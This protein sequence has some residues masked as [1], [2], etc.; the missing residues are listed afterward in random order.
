MNDVGKTVVEGIVAW[1][2]AR[3]ILVGVVG[4]VVVTAAVAYAH[5]LEFFALP[6]P[7]GTDGSIDVADAESLK[8]GAK[9]IRSDSYVLQLPPDWVPAACSQ[10]RA[11]AD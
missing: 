10:A 8:S 1:L 9:N 4:I 3:R 7:P 11:K 5:A 6:F 2:S